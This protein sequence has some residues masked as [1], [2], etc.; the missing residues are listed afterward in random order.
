MSPSVALPPASNASQPAS[1]RERHADLRTWFF[2]QALPFWWAHGTDHRQGGYFEKVTQ[3][4][5]IIDEPRRTRVTARQIYVFSVAHTMGWSGPSLQAMRHG[6]DF[7]L[8]R[9]RKPDGTY[10]SAVTV[11]GVIVD[12]RFDLYEQAFALFA[13]AHAYKADPGRTELPQLARQLFSRLRE[14]WSHPV[15]GFEES[16]PSSLPLRSNPHMHLLEALIAW[17]RL[18]PLEQR[19]EWRQAGSELVEL[20]LH[21]LIDRQT[22]AVKEYFNAQWAPMPDGTGRIVEPGHQFEWAWLLLEWMRL[23]SGSPALAET[24]RGLMDFAERHGVNQHGAALNELYDDGTP[25]DLNAKLWPQTERI[26]AWTTLAACT[27]VS[28]RQP[29]IAR[30]AQACESLQRYIHGARPGLWRESMDSS[31]RLNDQD[32]RASS[33]YHIV[34]AIDCLHGHRAMM[35]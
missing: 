33:L 5:G 32:C 15:L 30:A 21:H 17:D 7:L 28:M 20:C 18:G 35:A 29:H 26:K 16:R 23:T 31:G 19:P 8:E 4:G 9:Q 6:L 11:Q 25:K 1:L 24:A 14:G 34:C 10:A 13:M 2:E 27:D 22:G 3:A 12:D